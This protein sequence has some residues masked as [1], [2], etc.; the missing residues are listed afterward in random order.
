MG[1]DNGNATA[2]FT[3]YGLD[4]ERVEYYRR[5]RDCLPTVRTAEILP[6]LAS[7]YQAAARIDAEMQEFEAIASDIIKLQ[8]G[9]APIE[10]GYSYWEVAYHPEEWRRSA[11]SRSGSRPHF[12][13]EK[14]GP[15]NERTF[16]KRVD[17]PSKESSRRIASLEYLY[18]CARAETCTDLPNN[19]KAL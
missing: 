14:V 13:E 9:M 19:T 6:K 4:P 8:C 3:H 12:V 15:S 10:V 11:D 5:V 18:R 1:L 16:N 7:L 17:V 2:I